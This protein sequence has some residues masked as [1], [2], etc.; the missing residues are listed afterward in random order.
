MMINIISYDEQYNVMLI[1][2]NYYAI[3]A[4]LHNYRVTHLYTY[5]IHYI[6]THYN[7]MY[8][9]INKTQLL[10]ICVFLETTTIL[11]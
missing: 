6:S 3:I 7:S 10:H 8:F 1:F 2:F 5:C 11:S 4:Y 9:Y